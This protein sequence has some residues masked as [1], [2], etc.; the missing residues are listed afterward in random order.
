MGWGMN[1]GSIFVSKQLPAYI[2]YIS[3]L[4]PRLKLVV[5]C[6]ILCAVAHFASMKLGIP[7]VSLLTT[8]GE[9]W[10]DAAFESHCTPPSD[11]TIETSEKERKA[12]I[13]ASVET[14]KSE[15]I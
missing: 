13:A 14:A 1:F 2:K 6:P 15:L 12:F 3:K 8:A 7:D 11:N 4:M 5:Y 9:G 10:L